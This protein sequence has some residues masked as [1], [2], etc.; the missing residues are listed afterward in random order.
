MNTNTRRAQALAEKAQALTATTLP[1][2]RAWTCAEPWD[3][4]SRA[5]NAEGQV[6]LAEVA[7]GRARLASHIH[8][9]NAPGPD[10]RT[11]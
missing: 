8:A 1:E 9:I 5:R 6:K 4:A 3:D 2:V 10:A 7:A 11:Y